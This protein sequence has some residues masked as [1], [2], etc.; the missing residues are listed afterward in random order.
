MGER[1]NGSVFLQ[2][3]K[4][5][6]SIAEW[7][8]ALGLSGLKADCSWHE[9]DRADVGGGTKSPRIYPPHA[10]SFLF[11][12]TDFQIWA[13]NEPH[14]QASCDAK[15]LW[16]SRRGPSGCPTETG[17]DS[18]SSVRDPRL[19]TT[20]QG[21]TAR[22][23]NESPLE[24]PLLESGS[25]SSLYFYFGFSFTIQEKRL[26]PD[27]FITMLLLSSFLCVDNLSLSWWILFLA[28]IKASLVS[29]WSVSTR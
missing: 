22:G 26:G 24:S 28:V 23:M 14:G 18:T 25:A 2:P 15:A 19:G 21:K 20:C 6:R 29:C 9:S 3:L 11:P 10:R 12:R 16:I 13:L 27:I 8:P 17:T 7:E 4:C 5:G 1:G